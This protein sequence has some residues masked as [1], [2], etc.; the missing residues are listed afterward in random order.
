MK[1]A[2]KWI[3]IIVVSL[4]AILFV[5]LRV[6]V[7]QTKSHSPEEIITFTESGS[8]L[9]VYYNRPY[10]KGRK[11]FGNLVPFD[12]VWR[13]GANEASTFY[14]AKD[15]KIGDSSLPKGTYSLWTI[16]GEKEW[17]II[18]NSKEYGWGV[19]MKDGKPSREPEFDV[20]KVKVDSEPLKNEVEQFTIRFEEKPLL[21]LIMEWDSTRVS[22]DLN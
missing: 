11:I 2:L 15:L 17:T 5:S 20:L 13:T 21:K 7:Y 4:A 9:S 10:K 14:T 18:F 12:E 22:L 19:R 3:I 16:P 6:L 8:D 1:K